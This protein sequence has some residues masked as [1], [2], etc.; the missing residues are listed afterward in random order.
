MRLGNFEGRAFLALVL[1][2]TAAF[3]WM[4]RGFLLP[5]FWAAVFVV[6]FQPVHRRLLR[7]LHGRRGLAAALSGV[8]PSAASRRTSRS[9][10]KKKTTATTAIVNR[11]R[12][13]ARRPRRR[14]VIGV[15][16]VDLIPTP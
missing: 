9:G 3:L 10:R 14:R 2:T 1:T 16:G 11:T 12:P 13:T 7:K 5:V 6:L 8:S 15:S 4:V